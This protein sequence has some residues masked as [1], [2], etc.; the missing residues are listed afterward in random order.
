MIRS[1]RSRHLVPAAALLAVASLLVACSP[2]AGPLGTPSTPL[3]T[4][5]QS[6]PVPSEDATPDL[7]SLEPS[8]SAPATPPASAVPTGS[9]R[10]SATPP[11]TARPTTRPTATPAGTTIVRAYFVLGSATGNE[12]LVPVLREVPTTKAVATAA[13]RELLAGPSSVERAASPAISSA[14][15]A[16]TTLLGITIA[17]GVATVDLSREFESGG[18]TES[19]LSRLAQVVY[20]LT[21]FPTVQ[22]VRFELDG[23][24]VT[25]FGG[26]GI[27]LDD[28]VGREDYYEQLPAVFIDRPA[29]G[30][31]L[32]NPG[33]VSGLANVF[34]AQLHVELRDARDGLLAEQPVMAT[35]G[36]GCWGTWRTTLRYSVDRAQWGTLR[37]FDLSAR[38]GS[39]QNLVEYPVWLTPAG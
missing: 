20:T 8:A 29:W 24:P 27:M 17:D 31:S 15:P 36:T 12:G 7:S 34:E 1:V 38:D 11:P 26:E 19:M 16:G 32:G 39:V 5:D 6:L 3:P 9:S 14:I 25:V 22:G 10:P 35:C 21:Q 13:V 23:R 4:A 2:A 28:P 18:G 33:T 37:A 30:A